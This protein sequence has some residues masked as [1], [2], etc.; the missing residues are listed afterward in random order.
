ML[1]ADLRGSDWVDTCS[2]T[3]TAVETVGRAPD[4]QQAISQAVERWQGLVS[5]K[6]RRAGI[7]ADDARDL[8]CTVM[9]TLEGAVVAC[10][11]SRSDEPLQLAGRHLARLIT[12][13]R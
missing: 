6:L 13:Y 8:A 11:I 12:S 1:A 10:Q 9:N 7:G 4:I 3:A 5:D 2:F